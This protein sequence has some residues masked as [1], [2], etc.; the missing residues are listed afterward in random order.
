MR[1]RFSARAPDVGTADGFRW[2][3]AQG[4]LGSGAE[5]E[6]A[7]VGDIGRDGGLRVEDW[8]WEDV[9]WSFL[10]FLR[11]DSLPLTSERLGEPGR[12]RL[13]VDDFF[14]RSDGL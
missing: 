10:C 8:G 9:V 6:G 13:L 5:D 12:L 4:R 3:A 2:P 1:V 7:L 14:E 11:E